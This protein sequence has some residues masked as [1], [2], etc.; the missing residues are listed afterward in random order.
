MWML[1]PGHHFNAH[2]DSVGLGSGLRVVISNQLTNDG[3]AAV[4][5]NNQPKE[6]VYLFI[7]FWW[8]EG[9]GCLFSLLC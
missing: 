3:D 8:R 7:Y 6:E 9:K 4:P 1:S 2:S 5:W